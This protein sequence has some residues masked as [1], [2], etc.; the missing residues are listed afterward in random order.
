MT[1]TDVD[2][3]TAVASYNAGT[4]IARLAETYGVSYTVMRENLLKRGVQFRRQGRPRK[5]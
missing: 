2:W 4:P 1:R 3:D 5:A